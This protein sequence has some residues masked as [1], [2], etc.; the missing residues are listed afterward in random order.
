MI[1]DHALLPYRDHLNELHQEDISI[2]D[3]LMELLHD[4]AFDSLQSMLEVFDHLYLSLVNR[5]NDLLTFKKQTM[6]KMRQCLVEMALA[7]IAEDLDRVTEQEANAYR[8]TRQALFARAC[9]DDAGNAPQADMV[10][11]LIE[12]QRGLLVSLYKRD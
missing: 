3:N 11:E 4:S 12:E 9:R 5:F 10:E 6:T 1:V 2:L 8:E 7:S